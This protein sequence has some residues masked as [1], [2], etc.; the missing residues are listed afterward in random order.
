MI[1]TQG[2]L[3]LW[4]SD[5]GLR[6]ALTLDKRGLANSTTFQLR[7]P[8]LAMVS[9]PA[10]TVGKPGCRRRSCRNGR[11]EGQET[12]LITGVSDAQQLQSTWNP[13]SQDFLRKNVQRACCY[14][15]PFFLY[16]FIGHTTWH[17]GSYFPDQGLNHRPLQWKCRILIREVPAAYFQADLKPS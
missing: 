17:E 16:L 4:P 1:A 15:A 12:H 11:V 10:G 7:S 13:P 3:G 9:S 5:S 2:I 14:D 8:F 6:L